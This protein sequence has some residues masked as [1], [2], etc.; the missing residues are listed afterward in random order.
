MWF[1]SVNSVDPNPNFEQHQKVWIMNHNED[2]DTIVIIS[3]SSNTIEIVI[4]TIY[5]LVSTATIFVG[6]TKQILVTISTELYY[7]LHLAFQ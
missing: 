6:R 7:K 2:E 1:K 5:I 4:Y 3:S